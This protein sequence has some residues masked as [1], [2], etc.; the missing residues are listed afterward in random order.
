MKLLKLLLVALALT[1]GGYAEAK[2]VRNVPFTKVIYL[3]TPSGDQSGN[4][5]GSAK[6][7]W[8]DADLMAIEPGMVI[9]NVY[10]IVDEA[11][12]GM[13][14]LQI[15]DD[16]SASGFF[17]TAST[18]TFLATPQILA[19]NSTAKGSYLKDSSN[20]P[21]AKYYSAAGK[22]IK[23]DATGTLTTG[24]KL[25]VVIEGFVHAYP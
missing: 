4:S 18:D 24:G 14:A 8:V 15:G 19:W 22:E 7:A 16:D 5:Y 9:E 10:V 3:A 23:L 21:Q 6:S 25:R 1:V 17:P 12:A 20:N 11:V 2:A 13:T